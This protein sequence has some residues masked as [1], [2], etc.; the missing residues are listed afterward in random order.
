MGW[1]KVAAAL[2]A[3]ALAMGCETLDPTSQYTSFAGGKVSFQYGNFCGPNWP[4]RVSEDPQVQLRELQRFPAMDSID[5]ACR[6]HDI[7]FERAGRD[8]PACD[9]ALIG[10]LSLHNQRAFAIPANETSN[11]RMP[12]VNLANEI[13]TPFQ[14]KYLGREGIT[15]GLTALFAATGNDNADAAR[16]GDGEDLSAGETGV[17]MSIFTGALTAVSGMVTGFPDQPGRCQAVP[18]PALQANFTCHFQHHNRQ[19]QASGGD[20]ESVS[21]LNMADNGCAEATKQQFFPS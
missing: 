4:V 11:L 3:S 20:L 18:V 21:L 2:A 8:N 17:A 10:A 16:T 14:T 19:M 9:Y 5:A 7:C 15:Q 1:I 13:M 12:C 6:L